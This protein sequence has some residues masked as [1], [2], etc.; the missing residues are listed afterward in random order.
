MDPKLIS[1]FTRIFLEI[2]SGRNRSGV[3][4]NRQYIFFC[5]QNYDHRHHH[6]HHHH[7]QVEHKF[8]NVTFR[9]VAL[10]CKKTH[11]CLLLLVQYIFLNQT[12][13]FMIH[14][15][16]FFYL[17]RITYERSYSASISRNVTRKI[18]TRWYKYSDVDDDDDDDM[19]VLLLKWTLTAIYVYLFLAWAMKL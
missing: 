8:L 7:P 6:G 16:R 9:F 3:W 15:F 14:F 12:I 13:T 5:L 2:T 19:C 11:C 17:P 4:V 18:F 1:Q 10:S